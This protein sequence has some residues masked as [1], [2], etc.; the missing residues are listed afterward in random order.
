M[1]SSEGHFEIIKKDQSLFKTGKE[2]ENYSK[3]LL[4]YCR[5]T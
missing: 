4:N 1:G 5:L 3:R 2:C